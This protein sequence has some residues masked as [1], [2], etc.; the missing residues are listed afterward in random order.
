MGNKTGPLAYQEGDLPHAL[1]FNDKNKIGEGA[2]AEV[3]RI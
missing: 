3:Y 2:F 1:L